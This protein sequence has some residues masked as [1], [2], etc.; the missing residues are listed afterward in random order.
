MI[1]TASYTPDAAA[2]AFKSDVTNE[3]TGSNYTP[4]GVTLASK[5]LTFSSGTVT[6]GAADVAILQHAS[7]FTDGRI[8]VLY[9][10]TGT[11]A[12]SVLVAY[13]A[14]GSDCGNVNGDLVLQQDAIGILVAAP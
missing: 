11:D 6:F 9:K 12:T 10:S 4:G 8:G 1:C 5:T 13:A 2:H 7:G 14:F 3:V